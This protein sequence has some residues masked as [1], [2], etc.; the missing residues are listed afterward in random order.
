M[1]LKYK[2][3]LLSLL[4]VIV[5][6]LLSHQLNVELTESML[7]QAESISYVVTLAGIVFLFNWYNR[8]AVRVADDEEELPGNIILQ[9]KIMYY[10][11][12]INVMNACVLI[13]SI[14]ESIQLMTGISLLVVLISPAIFRT[15]REK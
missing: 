7:A 11:L 5:G 4:A 2:I 9:R 8:K 13:C 15:M 14:K 3:F 1:Q 6:V 10:L 12:F